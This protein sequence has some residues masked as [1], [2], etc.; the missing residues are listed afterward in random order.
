MIVANARQLTLIYCAEHESDE[1]DPKKR[2]MVKAFGRRL[3]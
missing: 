3:P 2:G 1:R